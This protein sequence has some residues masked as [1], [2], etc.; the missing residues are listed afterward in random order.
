MC[1]CY[2]LYSKSLDKYYIG[3]SCEDLQERLKK[4]LSNHKGYT[5]KTKDWIIVYFEEFPDKSSAYKRELQIKSWKSKIK[6]IEL[7][8]DSAEYSIPI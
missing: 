2:I 5:S 8:K 6:I 4:H 1:F 3:S 7:I